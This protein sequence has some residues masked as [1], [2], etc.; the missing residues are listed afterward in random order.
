MKHVVRSV[1][2]MSVAKISGLLHGCMGLLV[3]PFFLI[4]GFVGTFGDQNNP[5]PGAIGFVFAI[6]AP[7]L[8]GIL[9][10]IFGAIGGLLYNVFAKLV[11]GFEL[12]LEVQP[13]TP[14]AP[15]PLIPPA[16]PSI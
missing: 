2:V 11:G 4:A 7:F 6:L 8:C 10:F 9:G 13:A 5:F 3:A 1:G 12:E 16:T 14:Q 15:Y